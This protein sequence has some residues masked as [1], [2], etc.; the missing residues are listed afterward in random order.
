MKLIIKLHDL[1]GSESE[2]Q[3]MPSACFCSQCSYMKLKLFITTG[4]QIFRPFKSE[5]MQ[6]WI[7]FERSI[8]DHTNHFPRG[9]MQPLTLSPFTCLISSLLFGL[10]SY[11]A[12]LQIPQMSPPPCTLWKS[13][14]HIM[15][16]DKI[17]LKSL[18]CEDVWYDSLF[19]Y[20]SLRLGIPSAVAGWW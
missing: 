10:S 3:P 9:W 5:V 7:N 19:K 4:T 11:S 12:W 16:C 13:Y 17:N 8:T 15:A 14:I 18:C 1:D 20:L 6:K 2:F